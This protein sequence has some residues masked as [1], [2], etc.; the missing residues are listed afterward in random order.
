MQHDDW[1]HSLIIID[2][3]LKIN[4]PLNSLTKKNVDFIWSDECEEAFQTIINNLSSPSILK[5]PD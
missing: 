2:D 5:Y 1:L 4:Q 3:L